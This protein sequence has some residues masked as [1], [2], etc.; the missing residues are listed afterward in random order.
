MAT[1]NTSSPA[2]VPNPLN[3]IRVYNQSTVVNNQ[4]AATM[5]KASGTLLKEVAQVWGVG[6]SFADVTFVSGAP[7]SDVSTTAQNIWTFVIID[8]AQTN[9]GTLAYHTETSDRF[10][11]YI[12]AKTILD[13]GGSVLYQSDTSAETVAAGLFHELAE[14]LIDFTCNGWWQDANGTF[15]ASEVADPVESTPWIVQVNNQKVGLCSYI[16]PSWKDTEAPQGTQFDRAGVV[17]QPFQ[18][19]SGGYAVT[20]NSSGQSNTVWGERYPEWKMTHKARHGRRQRNYNL[21]LKKQNSQLEST[22]SSNKRQR[23]EEEES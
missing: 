2:H 3:H 13:N 8:S 18:V 12:F 17:T 1:H 11:G 20:I 10:I 5:C 19:A 6:S 22:V 9:D 4:D 16:F 15:W 14:A 21:R 23:S 7:P